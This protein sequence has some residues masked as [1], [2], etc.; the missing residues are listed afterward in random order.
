MLD[1]ADVNMIAKTKQFV[2]ETTNIEDA[3]MT[4]KS[5]TKHWLKITSISAQFIVYVIDIV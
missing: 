1:D 4:L 5:Y 2:L 3:A